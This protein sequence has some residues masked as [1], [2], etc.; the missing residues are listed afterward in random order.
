VNEQGQIEVETILGIAAVLVIFVGVMAITSF[1]NSETET[2]L[3]ISNEKNECK[4]IASIISF[5]ASGKGSSEI[6]IPINTDVNLFQDHLSISGNS[7]DFFGVA[8]PSQLSKGNAKI[9]ESNGVVYA[10][11]V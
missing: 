5:M 10:E 6:T 4:G 3:S 1:R 8:S 7:C 9:Y 2:I 11:N